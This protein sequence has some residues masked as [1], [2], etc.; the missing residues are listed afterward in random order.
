MEA[1]PGVGAHELYGSTQAGI[2]TSLRPPEALRRAGTVGHRWFMTE[3]VLL[4]DYGH[5]VVVCE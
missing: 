2:M 1:F 3:V 5:P 4:D